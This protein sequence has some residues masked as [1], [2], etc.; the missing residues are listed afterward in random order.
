MDGRFF[1]C[2]RFRKRTIEAL[3]RFDVAA[4]GAALARDPLGPFLDAYLLAG[5]A[6]R[7]TA[8]LAHIAHLRARFGDAATLAF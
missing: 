7:R 1:P 2:Q 4:F 6:E 8:V 3:E 5:L